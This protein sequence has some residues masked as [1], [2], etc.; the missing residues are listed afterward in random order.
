M[1]NAEVLPVTPERVPDFWRSVY[2][3]LAKIPGYDTKRTRMRLLSGQDRL[4]I[5]WAPDTVRGRPAICITGVIITT[6][7]DRPPSKRLVFRQTDPNAQKS[8]IIHVA[9]SRGIRDWLDCAIERIGRYAREHGCRQLYIMGHKG[10]RRHLTRW[11]STEWE[12]V[13]FSRDRPTKSTCRRLR[14]R[15]RPPYWMP[16]VPVPAAKWDRCLYTLMGTCYF[17]ERDESSQAA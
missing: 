12:M 17:K 8:L 1:A 5:S 11:Y 13:A 3:H 7:A 10:S 4:W 15:N 9:H 14:F 2:R 6:V 16:M